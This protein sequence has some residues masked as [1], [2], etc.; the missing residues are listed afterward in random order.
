MTP[1]IFGKSS[2]QLEVSFLR[3]VARA[4]K[5]GVKEPDSLVEVSVS[6]L[7]S[8]LSLK[9][10]VLTCG[11]GVSDDSRAIGDWTSQL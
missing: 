7:R 4:S 3:E 2:A 1:R 6:G 11:A 10:W 5:E 8:R 9:R